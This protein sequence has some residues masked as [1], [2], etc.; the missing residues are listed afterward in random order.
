VTSSILATDDPI[1]AANEFFKYAVVVQSFEKEK[2][3]LLKK[4][5]EAKKKTQ[6]YLDKTLGKLLE[7]EVETSPSQ[8][9]D[10]IMANLHQ[11]PPGAEEVSLYD[12][13]RDE[14]I[15]VKLKRKMSPQKQAENLY[16][17]GKNRKIEIEQLQK[18][19]EDKESY[20]QA[21]EKHLEEVAGITHFKE[22]RSFEKENNL[23][24][25]KKEQQ[26]TV[27][28][29]RFEV[30]GYEVLVGKSAKANDELLR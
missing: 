5:E 22:L 11:I 19:L 26:E 1:A 28:Y 3:A 27:P 6:N 18:N 25:S 30:D 20:L 4:L 2:N 17:K 16:R 12:F 15:E 9:A 8:L 14:Q 13:Y 10:I 23:L 21:L 29:K 7:L 24:T